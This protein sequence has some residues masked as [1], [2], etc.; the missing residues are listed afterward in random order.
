VKQKIHNKLNSLN[1]QGRTIYVL[2]GDF[3]SQQDNI[4]SGLDIKFLGTTSLNGCAFF[5]V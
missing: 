1:T 4:I 3:C 2:S 5:V